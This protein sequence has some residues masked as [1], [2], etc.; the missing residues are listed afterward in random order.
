AER[1]FKMMDRTTKVKDRTFKMM[2][3]IIKVTDR[4]IKGLLID[5]ALG[6]GNGVLRYFSSTNQSLT[7]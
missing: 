2:D 5:F 1:T 4:T 6:Q 7:P 3:R